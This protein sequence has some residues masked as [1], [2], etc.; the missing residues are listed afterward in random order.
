M[1]WSMLICGNSKVAQAIY[2]GDNYVD[3]SGIAGYGS[4]S[5]NSM[6]SSY[7]SESLSIAVNKP[8]MIV[9]L[10]YSGSNPSS[11]WSDALLNELPNKLPRNQAL[12]IWQQE[13][14]LSSSD[15]G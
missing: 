2:P 15:V 7:Y 9:E 5:W 14:P 6:F 8:I 13:Y 4:A 11:W 10:G 1:V 3:W 12:V